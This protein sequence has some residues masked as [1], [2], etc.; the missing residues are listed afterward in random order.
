MICL[1]AF[2][3]FKNI[4]AQQSYIVSG[5]TSSRAGANGLYTLAGTCNGGTPYYVMSNGGIQYSL[6][7]NSEGDI[8]QIGRIF[9]PSDPCTNTGFSRVFSTANLP[10]TSGWSSNA[11]VQVASPSLAYSGSQFVEN[12]NNIGTISTSIIV[13]HNNFSGIT[14]T[15]NNGD[16][17]VGTSKVTVTNL[18]AGLSASI[19]KNSNLQL[20][21]TL[22][23]AA[24]QHTNANEINN[25]NIA[26]G[27]SA[28]SNNDASVNLNSNMNF[29]VNFIE[30]INVGAGQTYTTIQSAVN[31]AQ[32]FDVL[33]LSAQTF[34]EAGI[35]INDKSL[36][37]IG[38]SPA[39]TI[40]QAAAQPG[41]ATNRIFNISFSSYN[42]ANFVNFEKLTLRNGNAE[43]NGGGVLAWQINVGFLNCSV[44]SNYTFTI[45]PHAYF[46]DG[47]GAIRIADG[48]LTATGTTFHNN[49]HNSVSNRPGDFMGG[50]AIFWLGQQSFGNTMLITNCTF[51][52]N[53]CGQYG[54]AILIRPTNN[55]IK[56]INSTFNGNSAGISGGAT[57]FGGASSAASTSFKN[58]IFF[59]NSAVSSG[60]EFASSF[61]MILNAT[62]C[63]MSNT[64]NM[65]NLS[66]NFINCIV[67][68]NPLLG[69]LAN[70]GG[71]TKTF[72]IAANSPAVNAGVSASDVPAADQRGFPMFGAKDIGSFELQLCMS[73]SS[74]TNLSICQTALPYSWNGLTFNNAG[75]QTKTGLVNAIGCDSS[76]TLNLSI[77][78]IVVGI[79]GATSVC[80]GSTIAM[81]NEVAGGVWSSIVGRATVN[82]A[83]GEVTGLNAGAAIIRYTLPNGCSATRNITVNALPP[84]PNIAYQPGT[85]SPQ[86]GANFCRNRTF[87]LDGFPAGGTWGAS[88]VANVNSSGVV[89]LGASI[90]AATVT[91]TFTSASGCS[92][93]RTIT[94]NV[95][96]CASRGIANSLQSTIDGGQFTIYPNPARSVI[97]VLSENVIGKGS[98]VVTDVLGKT[99]IT[100][101]LSIG[102]NV[103]NVS[104]LAKGIYFVSTITNEGT[105]TKKVV[106]E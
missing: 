75:T 86:V 11:V 23:G 4:N 99:L 81:S 73:T 72:A 56:I 24:S 8:W 65:G 92:N 78:N 27:N 57:Y 22:T 85:P 48:S 82:A 70:N 101:P 2:I 42:A 47:G 102:N 15:G 28:F 45:A 53:Y 35:S 62:N 1:F 17:Y 61:S 7:I 90:G 95:I 32:S 80:V 14:F 74:T 84:I 93:S 34:T 97:N 94:A 43:R 77:I 20:T 36:T 98:I 63:L 106:V 50:G 76:A 71:F 88:G 104:S 55:D 10:P 37:I 59:G 5:L 79:S 3:G 13:T 100:Q 26:F 46:G 40:I 19:I 29:T 38:Q 31:A 9:N 21:L 6:A 39:Q 89:T 91:Y 105:T 64:T 52:N 67:G 103:L 33:N 41:V 12:A 18:P 69:S 25:L 49:Q 60:P 51:S 96:A 44:E 66:I 16:N 58:S 54:G 87:T 68:Q 83:T 30:V